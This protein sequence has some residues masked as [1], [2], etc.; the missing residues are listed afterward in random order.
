MAVYDENIIRKS[1]DIFWYLVK[2]RK[3]SFEKDNDLYDAYCE[4]DEVQKLVKSMSESA[5]CEVERLGSVIYLIPDEDNTFLGYS[6]A[7]LKKELCK[8]GG[9]DKDYYLAQF[10]ILNLML[11][12]Y[13]GSGASAK[14]RDDLRVGE[15]ENMISDGLARGTAVLDEDAQSEA[16]IAFTNM[17]DAYEALKST[18]SFKGVRSKFTKQGFLNGILKFMEDQGLINYIE[19]DEMISVTRKF[20]NLM[21]Y[22]LLNDNNID[23][24]RRVMGELENEQN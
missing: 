12:F 18:D 16:G 24:V 19:A 20:D 9:T 14:S 22:D 13:D 15:L 7:E 2:Y 23:R 6:K 3:L 4:S 1:N 11:A 17:R 10:V 21:N 5:S 8:S